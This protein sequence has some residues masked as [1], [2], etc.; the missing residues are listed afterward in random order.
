MSNFK[1]E[2]K[3]DLR[4]SEKLDICINPE[5][6]E[7]FIECE[8]ADARQIYIVLRTI[9]E[10]FESG[11]IADLFITGGVNSNGQPVEREEF[12]NIIRTLRDK[13]DS[14]RQETEVTSINLGGDFNN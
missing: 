5:T 6:S 13:Y 1:K 4:Y 14:I 8:N 10:S 9:I 7:F 2:S 11:E 3:E 12:R